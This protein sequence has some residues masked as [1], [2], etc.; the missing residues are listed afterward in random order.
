[1]GPTRASQLVPTTG[2][3]GQGHFSATLNPTYLFTRTHITD[4]RG[5]D[6]ETVTQGRGFDVDNSLTVFLR[7]V[8]DMLPINVLES[9][10]AHV[11]LALERRDT[12]QR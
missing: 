5:C 7:E 4:D 12:A 2:W 8:A 3:P 1:M 6:F 10:H 9:P 11:E